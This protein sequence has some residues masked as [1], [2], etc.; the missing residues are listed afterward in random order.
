MTGAEWGL[1]ASVFLACAVET[2]EAVT[3]VLAVGFTRSW[4]SA[5]TGVGVALVVLAVVTAALGPALTSLP[6][7]A[8]RLIVGGLLLVFGLQWLRKANTPG[9]GLQGPS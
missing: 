3:I 6:L 1:A 2:V 8:L 7:S 5:F 4:R 9:L